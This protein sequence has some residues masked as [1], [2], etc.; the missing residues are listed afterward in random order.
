M[1][2]HC[3]SSLTLH[4]YSYQ[5]T[6]AQH[7]LKK[8]F[9]LVALLANRLSGG[10]L[11]LGESGPDQP[12]PLSPIEVSND[13]RSPNQ[14]RVTDRVGSVQTLAGLNQEYEA[15]MNGLRYLDIPFEI[16]SQVAGE[17]DLPKN[18]FGDTS[19]QEKIRALVSRHS[20]VFRRTLTPEPA[21]V[22]PLVLTV[23]EER[24]NC[25]ANSLP[26][27]LQTPAK[28]V[29]I[30]E[31]IEALLKAG[32]IRPCNRP[33]YSQVHLVPNPGEN[34]WRVTLDFR[35]LN[36]A[37]VQVGSW[38]L[39]NIEQLLQRIGSQKPKYFAKFDMTSGYWQF[40][41]AEESKNTLP[42]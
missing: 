28:Q 21:R 1:Y 11:R 39:P 38:P 31:H 20:G 10:N 37:T 23:D 19:L 7:T 32:I 14:L 35:N 29:I 33:Y 36:N 30:R 12:I 8:E 9:S 2:F 41:I 42:L 15:D 4:N 3:T 26:P 27:R 24:W 5:F 18:S 13:F 22:T 34:K 17:D 40:P 25:R 16:D 6:I